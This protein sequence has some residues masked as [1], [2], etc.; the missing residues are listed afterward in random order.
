MNIDLI[1]TNAADVIRGHEPFYKR[2]EYEDA[3]LE[4]AR[5]ATPP[6][7]STAKTFARMLENGDSRILNLYSAA[8]KVEELAAKDRADRRRAELEAG[9]AH[10]TRSLQKAELGERME[11]YAAASAKAGESEQQAFSRMLDSDP[12]MQLLYEQYRNA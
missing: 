6:G 7:D 3:M 8:R 9:Q 2:A 10:S 11:K 1:L 5:V 12:T 4:V